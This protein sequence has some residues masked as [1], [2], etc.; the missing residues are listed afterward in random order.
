MSSLKYQISSP[1]RKRRKRRKRRRRNRGKRF[2]RY[3]PLGQRRRM[4]KRRRRKRRRW[5]RWWSS[6]RFRLLS[7]RRRRRRRRR[8]WRY[9]VSRM[10]CIGLRRVWMIRYWSRCWLVKNMK[11][12]NSPT[13]A[14]YSERKRSKSTLKK[15]P[16]SW[17]EKKNQ[18]HPM[19]T[20]HSKIY[21]FH[22]L[23]RRLITRI[24]QAKKVIFQ[25]HF[26]L[27]FI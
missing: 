12:V 27:I 4:R 18:Y 9:S 24:S 11:T 22:Y 15:W 7:R 8:R 13:K 17:T 14:E 3:L 2:Q 1:E 20:A 16:W 5:W 26:I 6:T 21:N 23:K 19:F 10:M 25:P